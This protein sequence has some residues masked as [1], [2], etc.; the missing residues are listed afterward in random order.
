METGKTSKYFKY[1]IGEIV[2]VVIGILIAL[3][4]NNW[5]EN[6]KE[7]F[8]EAKIL[9]TL[10]EEFL[11]NK[12]TLDSTLTF[13]SATEDAL[14]FVLKN[15]DNDPKIDLTPVQLDSILY[16]TISNPYWKKSEYTL[17]NLENSGKLSNLSNQKLKAQLYEY[18][19]AVTDITD[20]DEDATC[21]FNHLLNYFKENGSLRNLDATGTHIKE[22]RTA[23]NYNHIKFFSDLVFENAI[24]DCLVYIRQRIE[25][26]NV[27]KTIINEIISIT[28]NSDD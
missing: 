19:L 1:A 7:K 20:K 3:S 21:G 26:Y 22:G 11:E 12:H 9:K 15:I 24:D 17:K 4:I 27:V 10:N 28:N 18:S 25:R 16:Y 6:R 14:S 2:L 8:N 13:L 23:L 5:N